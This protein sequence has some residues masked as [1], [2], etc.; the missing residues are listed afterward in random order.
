MVLEHWLA[1]D[2][3]VLS[4][5]GSYNDIADHIHKIPV[6]TGNI[7]AAGNVGSG[8]FYGVELKGGIRLD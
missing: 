2:Q 3:G 7:S 1:D 8:E 4:L 6:R 5:R